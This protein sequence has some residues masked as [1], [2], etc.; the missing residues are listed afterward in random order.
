MT[1]MRKTAICPTWDDV[2]AV[3]DEEIQR[4]PQTYRAA[5]VLCILQGKSGPQ[6]AA[7]LGV[8]EGP[9]WT[10]LTRARQLLQ[11]RLTRR[12]IK[13]AA[14]L[15]ALA[16]TD[17][18]AQ[19][20][21]SAVLALATVRSGLL[22]AAGESAAGV[23]PSHVAALAA[24]VT[25]AMFLTKAKIA[26][27]LLFAVGL[28]ATGASV[29][30]CQALAA[31]ATPPVAQKAEPPAKGEAKPQTA[32]TADNVK[33]EKGDTVAF[34]GR[35]FDPDGKPFVGAKVYLLSHDGKGESAARVSATTDTEG[36]FRLTMSR[37]KPFSAVL[38]VADR[39]GPAWVT[40]FRKPHD[41]MLRLV[42]DDVPIKGR[43][44]D[45]QGKPVAGVSIKI[46]ALKASPKDNLDSWLEDTKVRSDGRALERD[47]LT[48]LS[49]QTL[50]KLF[51]PVTT[52]QEGRFRLTGIG[53]ERI[54]AV[55][56]EGPTIETQEIN[57]ATRR[58]LA[59]ITLPADQ[60]LSE[61]L[62]YYGPSFDHAA[63][64]GRAIAGVVRDRTTGKPV[65]GVVVRPELTVGN[66]PYRTQTTTD[67][68]GRYRLTGLGKGGDERPV[69]V[70]ALP[71]DGTPY[72]A[73]KRRVDGPGLG[74][75]TLDFE[76]KKGVWL[77]GK[78]TDQATGRG[79]ESE[80]HYAVFSDA[81]DKKDG[82]TLYIQQANNA[83]AGRTD[84]QGRFRILAYPGRGLVGCRSIGDEREHYR[85][86]AGAVEIV[87]GKEGTI[88][89]VVVFATYP[90][91]VFAANADAWKEVNPATGVKIVPCDI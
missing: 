85:I 87:R 36:R 40:D 30:T 28:V 70:L 71:P 69:T 29:L 34:S 84:T 10:R 68:E 32:R 43:I 77:H 55:I 52:D 49:V 37:D 19:A 88:G 42:N 46:N 6:A 18:A 44:V 26:V 5:F 54:A 65:A 56:A 20:G 89:S 50:A 51:P 9:V 8:K 64:P 23:I 14:V 15:A 13:L 3:L 45:L 74:S 21:V 66:P 25:R 60:V 48:M 61:Q 57:V 62:S 24:G 17:S 73:M 83:N 91:D 1:L 41:L 39:C 31:K 12:G 90:F 81:L 75:V 58:S 80:L 86:A 33:D 59:K 47:H 7:E 16:V 63:P 35:V 2:Q 38:A 72:L 53:R 4:L 22:V 27:A 78:V 76:L 67:A 79:V 11:R 82:E